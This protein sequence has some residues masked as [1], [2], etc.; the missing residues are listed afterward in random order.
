MNL[1][2]AERN[3]INLRNI[4]INKSSIQSNP[5]QEPRRPVKLSTN[6]KSA[7][8][9][10]KVEIEKIRAD[11]MRLDE[12]MNMGSHRSGTDDSYLNQKTLQTPSHQSATNKRKSVEKW[13]VPKAEKLEEQK[14]A[15][16]KAMLRDKEDRSRN[17]TDFKLNSLGNSMASISVDQQGM[18]QAGRSPSE[19]LSA[20]SQA[21][22]N[23]GDPINSQE[24][25]I[26]VM[27]FNPVP[28]PTI[29]PVLP[30]H[31]P[32]DGSQPKASPKQ[33]FNQISAPSLTT[34]PKPSK[35]QQQSP[36]LPADPTPT[37]P[38]VPEQPRH[39]R[40][41]PAEPPSPQT[42]ETPRDDLNAMG[43]LQL[44]SQQF[45]S[46]GDDGGRGL[47]DDNRFE[48]EECNVLIDE[49]HSPGK[50]MVME[51]KAVV[52][53]GSSFPGEEGSRELKSSRGVSGRDDDDLRG[54]KD[55][56][57]SRAL[58]EDIPFG[59]QLNSMNSLTNHIEG[60]NEF[61]SPLIEA[62]GTTSSRK[63]STE[64]NGVSSQ[65]LPTQTSNKLVIEEKPNEQ[66]SSPAVTPSS[67][68]PESPASIESQPP[69]NKNKLT[70]N[71]G[72]IT[73][74]SSETVQ[75]LIELP[76]MPIELGIPI[77]DQDLVG[78][79]KAASEFL[80]DNIQQKEQKAKNRTKEI[81]S[82]L[83]CAEVLNNLFDELMTE[84]VIVRKL[85]Q[86]KFYP[87]KGI[88]TNIKAVKK[89]LAKLCDFVSSKL[90]FN[91]G[92]FSN[93][94]LLQLNCPLG[95][96]PQERLRLFHSETDD[97]NEDSSYAKISYEQVMDIEIYFDFEERL[98]EAEGADGHGEMSEIFQLEIEHIHNK[99]LFDC[100][101][102]AL[103]SFRIFG[104]KGQ[105]LALRKRS[106]VPNKIN[107]E[108]LPV[109]LTKAA[110]KVVEW[111]T[112]MCGFIPFKDDSFIQVPRALDE[113]TLNQIKE[114][115][116][117]RL[118]TEEVKE[119]LI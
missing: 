106:K 88:K 74:E 92:N 10:L 105:P 90:E 36:R 13:S 44:D 31:S 93:G 65:P 102:E 99:L 11:S 9:N 4:A 22:K 100:L 6:D 25:P 97:E 15:L 47:D 61:R 40:T 37:I 57:T 101:N 17:V 72:A 5:S 111:S 77:Q 45:P 18:I 89:Y 46:P 75:D 79:P 63:G 70:T 95:P 115:R 113:D 62:M 53:L 119:M 85:F 49:I 35:P 71:N 112:F 82:D 114:D 73:I 43:S 58:R 56:S 27:V 20:R 76:K 98:M 28:K 86:M 84:E 14:I 116:L 33:L 83:I 2:K 26:S 16:A 8:P 38:A 87:P 24:R 94:C 80:M 21:N 30:Q 51:E 23:K 91:K 81:K 59:F 42:L 67:K 68:Q 110:Q 117:V 107:N 60:K 39:K 34:E 29:N 50:V 78:S 48:R 103:D 55:S 109:V 7:L 54:G 32:K 12:Q 1:Q 52:D 69:S 3:F 108:E 66:K 104:L 118:L 19:K 64:P 96:T 41:E